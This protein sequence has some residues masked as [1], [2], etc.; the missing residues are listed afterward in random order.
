MNFAKFSRTP[1]FTVHLRVLTATTLRSLFSEILSVFASEKLI[2]LLLKVNS[3]NIFADQFRRKRCFTHNKRKLRVR[4]TL[5]EKPARS[6]C[7]FVTVKFDI[8][9]IISNN[10]SPGRK[11]V[12]KRT[13]VLQK[14]SS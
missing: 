14:Q 9:I 13:C 7:A 1:F 4:I 11:T 3:R 8:C 2:R 10:T 6:R 12:I 5:P